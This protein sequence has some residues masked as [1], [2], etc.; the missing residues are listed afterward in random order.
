MWEVIST[1]ILIEKDQTL[2]C[3]YFESPIGMVTLQFFQQCKCQTVQR[4]QMD[5]PKDKQISAR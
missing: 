1:K 4:G 2:M 3:N 5:K